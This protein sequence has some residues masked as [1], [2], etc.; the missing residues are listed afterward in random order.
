MGCFI[1]ATATL[2]SRKRKS[3]SLLKEKASDEWNFNLWS[4]FFWLEG[5]TKQ[6]SLSSLLRSVFPPHLPISLRHSC[7]LL[8]PDGFCPSL[9]SP[10]GLLMLAVRGWPAKARQ[11]AFGRGNIGST[12]QLRKLQIGTLYIPCTE[13][14]PGPGGGQWMTRTTMNSQGLEVTNALRAALS[15]LPLASGATLPGYF[16]FSPCNFKVHFNNEGD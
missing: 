14:G 1:L 7:P 9:S 15:L 8:C 11:S 2:V 13:Q 5:N 6:L 12:P 16:A 4:Q 10:D 3:S